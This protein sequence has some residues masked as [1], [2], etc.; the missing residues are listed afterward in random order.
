MKR[1]FFAVAVACLVGCGGGN[2]G[3]SSGGNSGGNGSGNGGNTSGGSTSG[4]TGSS[5]SDS[6]TEQVNGGCPSNPSTLTGSKSDGESCSASTECQPTCCSCSSGSNQWLA[7]YC[8]N[9][10]CNSSGAC[11]ATR[12]DSSFCQ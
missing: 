1:I 8:L 6:N 7:V 3:S 4:T 9:G 12:D 11:A 5:S 2:S 10:K